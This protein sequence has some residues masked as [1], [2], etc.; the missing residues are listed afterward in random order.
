[1]TRFI[2]MPQ[3]LEVTGASESTIYRWEAEGSF[4][5]RVKLG[6]RAIG[7]DA[8]EVERWAEDRAKSSSDASRG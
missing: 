1:M 4:P 8:R 6:K 3:V 2:R 7:W 5:K